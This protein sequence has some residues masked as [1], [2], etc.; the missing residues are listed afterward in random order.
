[1]YAGKVID[2]SP[3]WTDR[4][5][6]ASRALLTSATPTLAGAPTAGALPPHGDRHVR[7]SRSLRTC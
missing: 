6:A 4:G 2:L 1:M 7:K 3:L 5:L